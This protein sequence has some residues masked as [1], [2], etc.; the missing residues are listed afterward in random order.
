MLI[1][2]Y[3]LIHTGPVQPN[4]ENSNG[5]NSWVDSIRAAR[6]A[7]LM[8]LA[9]SNPDSTLSAST[10]GVHLRRALRAFAS[11]SDDIDD[12]AKL[13]ETGYENETSVG[14]PQ[15]GPSST[16]TSRFR[17]RRAQLVNFLPPV[18]IPDAK[19]DTCMRCGRPFGFVLD[20]RLGDVFGWGFGKGNTSGAEGKQKSETE[21]DESE[22]HQVGKRVGGGGAWRRKHHCR[23]C[24]RVVCSACSGKVFYARF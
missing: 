20:L 22:G 9:L 3:A 15:A 11:E 1:G 24:G 17:P 2:R 18:W 14:N 8:A 10:S 7:R 13:E 23:L 6:A 12:G 16:G 4:A 5:L 19:T 21:R